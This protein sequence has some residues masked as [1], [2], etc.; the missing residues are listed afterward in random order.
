MSEQWLALLMLGLGEQH[1]TWRIQQRRQQQVFHPAGIQ[2]PHRVAQR[3]AADQ[4]VLGALG[5]GMFIGFATPAEQH[6]VRRRPQVRH[7]NHRRGEVDQAGVGA[8]GKQRDQQENL[9]HHVGQPQRIDR[10]VVG[11]FLFQKRGHGLVP[12]RGKQD[13]GAQQR[14]RQQR[15]EQR[16][17]QTKADQQRAPWPDDVFQHRRQ[18]RVLQ[19]R[20]FWLAHDPQRQHI[21]QHQQRQHAEKTDHRGAADIGAFLRPC[22][23]HAGALDAD[24]HE[25]RHQHHVAHLIH[26]P[27][28]ARVAA[29]PD[30]AGKDI[31]LERHRRNHDEHDQRHDLGDRGHLIDEGRLLDPAHHQKMHGPQQHRRTADGD[32]RVALAKHREEVTERAEQQHEITDVAQPGADPVTP[33]GRETHVVAKPGLGVGVDAGVQLRLAVG[34]GLEHERQGQHADGGDSPADQDRPGIG[35]RCHVL[36]QGK[37]SPANHRTYNQGDQRTKAQLLRRLRH[38]CLP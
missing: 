37:N 22:R 20:Q 34:E 14:P 11:V 15:A 35:A 10:H 26:H 12:R 36:R 9:N 17:R 21:D 23:V 25:H 7:Q 32:R 27:A 31:G 8:G 16:H 1:H 33:G 30:V 13:F 5:R 38:S 4:Q 3:Y 19:G 18:R 2:Q 24:E 28:E 6:R 29:A